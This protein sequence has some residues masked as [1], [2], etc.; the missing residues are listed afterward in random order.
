MSK[1]E[2]KGNWLFTLCIFDLWLGMDKT[3]ITRTAVNVLQPK[4]ATVHRANLI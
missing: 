2:A 3:D 1:Q 4:K